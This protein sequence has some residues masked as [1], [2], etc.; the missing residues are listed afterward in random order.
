MGIARR[1]RA[2]L[3]KYFDEPPT[4]LSLAGYISAR[5]TA[6]LMQS[7]KSL[8]RASVYEAFARRSSV[9]LDGFRIEVANGRLQSAFVTQ[10]MM[11]LDGRVIG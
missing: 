10:S 2:A 7:A 11:S 1:Y 9:D 8:T 5:Y 6:Q 3:A 4:A